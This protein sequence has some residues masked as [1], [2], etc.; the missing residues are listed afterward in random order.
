MAKKVKEKD[1][2]DYYWEDIKKLKNSAPLLTVE[3][4]FEL[5]KRISEGD[6]YARQKMIES[7]LRLVTKIARGYTNRGLSFNDLISEGNIGLIEAVEK[8][9]Y[10]KGYKFSTYAHWWIEQNIR[11]ALSNKS[12]VIRIPINK[13]NLLRRVKRLESEGKSLEEIAEFLEKPKERIEKVLLMSSTS[14]LD[15]YVNEDGST[16]ETVIEEDKNYNQEESI[17]I[18]E[19]INAIIENLNARERGIIELRYGLNGNE[20]L[21]LEETGKVFK[22]T[23]ERVRQIQEK[24]IKKLSRKLSLKDNNL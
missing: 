5:G 21:T 22:I 9:D 11:R 23:R 3:E 14:S 10:L 19:A 13:L 7:N 4:E 16:L 12:R 1:L 20:E 15:V 2:E 18:K 6:E 8:Y 24:A 17:G